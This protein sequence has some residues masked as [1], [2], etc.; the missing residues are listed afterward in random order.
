MDKKADISVFSAVRLGFFTNVLNPKAT[1]FFLALFTQVINPATP[2]WLKAIYGIEMSLVQF[3]WFALIAYMFSHRQIKT[4]INF[5]Q[6]Y[7]ER[8]MGAILIALGIRIALS[9]SK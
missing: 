7:V 9:S 8:A 3:L 5:I 4:P 6:R 1:L 2:L